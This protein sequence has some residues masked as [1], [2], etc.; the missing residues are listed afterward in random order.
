M[1]LISILFT[2]VL[3]LL[4]NKII[5]QFILFMVIEIIIFIIKF[6]LKLAQSRVSNIMH[7]IPIKYTYSDKPQI[8]INNDGNYN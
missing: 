1:V 2:V 3:L 5:F 4:L 8:L 7:L 6:Q